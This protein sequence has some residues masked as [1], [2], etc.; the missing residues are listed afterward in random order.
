MRRGRILTEPAALGFGGRNVWAA[1]TILVVH[2]AGAEAPW[3]LTE[4]LGLR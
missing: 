3:S 1:E 4:G 2:R